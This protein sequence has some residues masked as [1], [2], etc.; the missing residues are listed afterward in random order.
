GR[1]RG[2]R[3]EPSGAR[4]RGRLVGGRGG[5]VAAIDLDTADEA[6]A[7]IDVEYEELP[8]VLDPMAAMEAEAPILHPDLLTYEGLF[9]QPTIPNVHSHMLAERGDLDKHFAESDVIFEHTFTTSAQHQGY[10]EPY[11][12][13]VAI[14]ASGR[15]DVWMS[16][17]GPFNLRSHLAAALDLPQDWV[18][19]NPA[20]IG[21]EFGG[22]GSPMD[23]PVAY[24]LARRTGKPVKMVM[25]YTEELIARHPPP[26]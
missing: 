18:R 25:T 13:L 26:P 9:G 1:G 4:A 10:L 12:V 5:P 20:H 11:S 19:C 2:R 16:N 6:I 24:Q 23:A 8:A 14:D 15:P 21:G 22:K 3:A 7:L 17:K